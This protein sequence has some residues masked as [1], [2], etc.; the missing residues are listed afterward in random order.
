MDAAIGTL[1]CMG[2][3]IPHSMGLG[4]GCFMVF[5]NGTS[6]KS[7]VVDGR[8]AAPLASFKNMFYGN[9]T[10]AKRGGLSI[11]VPGELAG[12]IW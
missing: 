10:T 12:K 3:V 1:L 2:V 9:A 5:Y 4:G 7:T 6:R 8:E 11:A